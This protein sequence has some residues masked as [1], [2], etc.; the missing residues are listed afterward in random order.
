MMVCMCATS[1]DVR[2]VCPWQFV[3]WTSGSQSVLRGSLG[4]RYQF[5]GDPWIHFC[6]CCFEICLLF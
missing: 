2:V 1:R 6:N 5:P 4:I 3:V